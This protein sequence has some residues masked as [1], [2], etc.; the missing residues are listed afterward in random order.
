MSIKE[1]LPPVEMTIVPQEWILQDPSTFTEWFKGLPVFQGVYEDYKKLG[2]A[3]KAT[4]LPP[5]TNALGMNTTANCLLSP[6]KL[7][8]EQKKKFYLLWH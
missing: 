1:D 8:D 2:S 5:R 7:D 4:M 6:D 3:E